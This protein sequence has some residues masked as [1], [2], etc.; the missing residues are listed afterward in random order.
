MFLK[1]FTEGINK[2]WINL[3]TVQ[4][5]VQKYK[6]FK[7]KTVPTKD[8]T[9]MITKIG[10]EFADSVGLEFELEI[11]KVSDLPDEFVISG[12]FNEDTLKI[13]F[14]YTDKEI[15][16]TEIL[17]DY[18]YNDFPGFIKHEI[19]HYQQFKIRDNLDKETY[20]ELEGGRIDRDG[21]KYIDG[22]L[23]H[24]DEIEA[25]AMNA[26]SEIYRKF[27]KDSINIIQKDI[28]K[29]VKVSDAM[30]D[31]YKLVRKDKKL[32][33]K[34]ISKVILYLKDKNV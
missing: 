6:K 15:F 28:K 7:G 27:K 18:L 26:A 23:G 20:R 33:N 30:S 34:F 3:K 8:I 17:W 22:N 11:E 4:K 21:P 29:T 5:E 1:M 16:I 24:K 19:L 25:Y 10:T 9:K 14:N 13:E 31:Y 2:P 32:W 12:A